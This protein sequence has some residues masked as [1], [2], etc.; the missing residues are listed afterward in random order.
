M[1]NQVEM[2]MKAETLTNISSELQSMLLS[3]TETNTKTK[4]IKTYLCS[5]E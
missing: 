5:L 4:A 3:L 1:Q 2:T